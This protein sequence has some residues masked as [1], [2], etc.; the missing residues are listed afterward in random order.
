MKDNDLKRKKPAL[1]VLFVC[2]GNICRS[3]TAEAAFRR[4]VQ[5]RSL[6]YVIQIDSAGTHG[7]HVGAPPD[8]RACAAAARRGYDLSS[9]TARKVTAEDFR[10][11]QY[12]LAMD[13]ENLSSLEAIKPADAIAETRLFTDF[14][15][16]FTGQEVPDPYSGGRQDFEQVLNMVEDASAGLME[17]LL[18]NDLGKKKIV[19]PR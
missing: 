1:K 8:S 9:L 3:P 13:E 19:P 6:Q 5:A 17:H 16:R 15:A 12:M 11:F 10:E 2:M 18:A 4:L 7:Y 14:S